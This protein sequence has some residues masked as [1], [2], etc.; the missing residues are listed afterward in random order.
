MTD[1]GESWTPADPAERFSAVETKEITKVRQDEMRSSRTPQQAIDL[2]ALLKRSLARSMPRARTAP[3]R[4]KPPARKA[5]MHAGASP[6]G[7]MKSATKR[8][9]A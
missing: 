7:S 2:T 9:Q 3:P 5:P 1:Q 8:K 4:P 6:R